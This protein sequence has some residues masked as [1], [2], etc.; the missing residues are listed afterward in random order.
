MD[1]KTYVDK[2]GLSARASNA[3]RRSHYHHVEDIL[4]LTEDDLRKLSN[5]GEKS[6]KEIMQKIAEI[7]AELAPE[8][9]DVKEKT[10]EPVHLLQ[11]NQ[12]V[13]SINGQPIPDS[14]M[15]KLSLKSYRFLKKNEIETLNELLSLSNKKLAAM[16]ASD[17]VSSE[18]MNFAD[19]CVDKLSN[20][21]NAAETKEEPPKEVAEEPAVQPENVEIASIVSN[22]TVKPTE[23][24]ESVELTPVV[25]EKEKSTDIHSLIRDK[26][27]QNKIVEYVQHHDF[28]IMASALDTPLKA[29]I[30]KTCYKKMSEIVLNDRDSWSVI[31]GVGE[32]KIDGIMNFIDSYLSKN[33]NEIIAYCE[34]DN[35]VLFDP[36]T[37][38]KRILGLFSDDNFAEFSYDEI[39]ESLEM[40]DKDLKKQ[41]NGILV[42]LLYNGKINKND[43]DKYNRVLPSFFDFLDKAKTLNPEDVKVLKLRLDGKKE[44]EIGQSQ[45]VSKQSIDQRLKRVRKNILDELYSSEGLRNF[46]EDQYSYLFKNYKFDDKTADEWLNINA[47]TYSYLKYICKHKTS[48]LKPIKNALNDSCLDENI[49]S[50]IRE[51]S[52]SDKLCIDGTWIDKNR[53]SILEYVISTSCK[54]DTSIECVRTLFLRFKESHEEIRNISPYDVRTI[55]NKCRTE[56][57][58]V[59]YKY[60]KKIRSYNFEEYDFSE[61]LDTLDL[62]SYENTEISTLEFINKY[63]DLMRKY[64]LRDE[65]ELYNLLS[66]IV[67]KEEYPEIDFSKMPVIGFGEY[68]HTYHTPYNRVSS[69]DE[70]IPVL[71]AVS[72]PEFSNNSAEAVILDRIS[73]EV[74]ANFNFGGANEQQK[75]AISTT[76]GPLLIIAGPGTGKTFTLVKRIVYLITEKKVK[77]EEIMVATFTEKAAKEL[78]TRITTELNIINVQVNLNEMYI[79]TFHSI[80]LRILKENIAY[81]RLK[82][83]FKMLDAFEQKYLIFQK[84]HTFEHLQYFEQVMGEHK[85]KWSLA[86]KIQKIVCNLTE[87]LVD[88]QKM[89]KDS[90]DRVVGVGHILNS[91]QYIIQK[92]N[93]IDFSTVQTETYRLLNEHPEILNKIQEKIK[94]VMVD[95]Y[96]DTNYIQELLV[97]TIAGDRANICVVG[98]DDQGLY[99]FRGATIRNI[100]EF[101]S[102]FQNGICKRVDLTVNYRSEKDIIDF[103]NKWMNS[104]YCFRWGNCR[105]SKTIVPGKPNYSTE[106]TVLKCSSLDKEDWYLKVYNFINNLKNQNVITDYN[107][108]AFLCSS[109]K[110]DNVK[111]L[112]NYLEES[113]IPVYSPRSS[114]FFER[115]E[116]ELALGCLIKCFPKF[117]SALSN[118]CFDFP[119]RELIGYYEL[120]V[121]NAKKIINSNNNLKIWISGCSKKNCTLSGLMYQLFQFEPFK[122]YLDTN[123]GSGVHNERAPRNMS[124]LISLITRYE[125]LHKCSHCNMQI[126]ESYGTLEKFFNMYMKFLYR[127]GIEEYE[128]ESEYAPSG[129]VSF[130]TIHQSKGMEFP[131][132]MVDSL[133]ETPRANN[134]DILELAESNNYLHRKQFETK[135]YIKYF[136]FWR[137]YYT[138]FSRAQNLLVLACCESKRVP[139]QCF[140]SV[141]NCLPSVESVDFSQT[142]LEKVKNLNLKKTYSFTSHVELYENC[143]RQYKFFQEYDFKQIKNNSTFFGTL[144]HETIEDV[145]R[146]ALRHEE[147]TITPD[148]IR[149]WLDTNY[150]TLSGNSHSYLGDDKLDAAYD[151]V[152]AYV[153]RIENGNG[154][155]NEFNIGKGKAAWKYI[156][157]AEVD[158]SLVKDNYILSGKIDLIQG[159]GDTVEIVDFKSGKK[160]ADISQS[161]SIKRYRQQLE[162]YAYLVE[163]NTGKSVSRMHL[164]YTSEVKGN[165]L[166][167]FEKSD[168]SV[169]RTMDNFDNIVDKIQNHDFTSSPM[170]SSA[171]SECD[172]KYYCGRCNK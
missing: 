83:N 51:F 40:T 4:N 148:M 160:P 60:G 59:L 114:M 32:K 157:D 117:S 48:D 144:V 112:M 44:K 92:E 50:K 33:E 94:Y 102:H 151:Q 24:A 145:H 39:C 52:D 67:D 164:Y 126:P 28:D 121:S 133:R 26:A 124:T 78:I 100:L 43:N 116:V 54:E 120:C 110:N 106:K 36:K 35:S 81:T 131:V 64:D 130:L 99:R 167:T 105:Y 115:E 111:G 2:I 79:G 45:G 69:I 55:E 16:G 66:K 91:Y 41:V 103:Y 86:G 34:G 123:V 15:Q 82:K 113:G 18:I 57:Y 23:P 141:Y 47:D 118:H 11:N 80:C 149:R 7:K 21:E 137:K 127:A 96:Q 107:Q 87:E 49:K 61:L 37:I 27:Y 73:D 25:T 147:D 46:A 108:V 29:V 163:Q 6:V 5:L 150:S 122:G 53:D 75:I 85:P 10:S 158:V 1:G 56:Y 143:A 76:E 135:E 170:K 13:E 129:C 169:K 152:K 38:E 31:K 125:Q 98:D 153:D 71:P 138:A 136:D 72:V 88:V 140:S 8:V 168:E 155:G 9:K 70:E 146:A 142:K 162:V 156:Q 63:P 128:D 12:T 165:P 62:G 74:S 65:Y 172:L 154:Y 109:V 161:E 139:S 104:T 20:S 3:L 30:S 97:L 42:S 17:E 132:V 68:E 171:C 119:D 90:N 58:S 77:P 89:L 101:S 95:E 93:L 134:N 22:E 166:I 84:I 159:K 14:L 19:Y